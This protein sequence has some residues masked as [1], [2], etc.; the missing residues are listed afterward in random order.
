[1][2]CA[3]PLFVTEELESF[4]SLSDI[5]AWVPLQGDATEQTSE[6]GSLLHVLG[7]TVNTPMPATHEAR[8]ATPW[9]NVVFA[10]DSA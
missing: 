7:A 3:L 5:I 8:I 9:Q 2:Y 4:A 6:L 10:S 1:M